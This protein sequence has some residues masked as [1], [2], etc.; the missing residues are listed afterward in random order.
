[1]KS[2]L[3]VDDESHVLDGLRRMLYPLRGEW[4]MTFATSGTEA[5]RS[6]AA[7]PCDVIVTDMRMPGI[8][9]AELLAQVS[10]HYP[11]IVRIVLSGMCDR[12]QSLASAVSAH[13]FLSKP[14][15]PAVLKKVVDRAVGIQATL[16]NP[17]LVNFISRLKS[18]PSIPAVYMEL[19]QAARDPDVSAAELGAI[20]SKDLA[21]ASKV[22]H[23]AS[24]S[25]FGI[26]RPVLNP[27]EAC[28]YLGIETIQALALSLGV[29]SQYRQTG[30]FSVEDLQ[31]HSLRTANLA[32][33]LAT[34]EQFSKS[35]GEEAFL[36]GMLH[37][38]GKLVLA[39]NYPREYDHCIALAKDGD[40]PIVNAESDTFGITHADAGMY[41]L[42][43]WGLP[44]TIVEAVALHHRPSG[45]K[46]YSP[47]ALAMVHVANVLAREEENQPTLNFDMEYLS[48]LGLDS[49]F[50]RWRLLSRRIKEEA[51]P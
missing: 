5:L 38:V 34:A 9:G 51:G 6:L 13:Q 21:M 39:T 1:V 27:A 8:S 22:L 29:F 14:C 43:L 45:S 20:V 36:G 2:I 48:A 32:K 46:A 11:H 28:V 10:Q 26:R 16:R 31:T 18:L 49:R 3:F 23:L 35:A 24:S 42:R 41:L 4:R 44:D 47:G 19:V 7:A 50:A 15:D 33:V 37:D 25:L 17:A 40:V 12:E 30:Q